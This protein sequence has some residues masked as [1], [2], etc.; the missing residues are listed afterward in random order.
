MCA[1]SGLDAG[2]VIA[3]DN[4]D[5]LLS[6]P[7]SACAPAGA[8]STLSWDPELLLYT[9]DALG[10]AL[11]LQGSS[12]DGSITLVVSVSRSADCRVILQVRS[13]A[14]ILQTTGCSAGN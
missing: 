6:Y 1:A 5:V 11:T 3:L 14:L 12:I 10:G 8:L 7:V 4:P 2:G 9:G 13:C